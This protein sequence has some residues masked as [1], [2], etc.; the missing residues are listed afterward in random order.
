MKYKKKKLTND[1][2]SPSKH[3]VADRCTNDNGQTKPYIV[4][5]E[6]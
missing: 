6:D 3:E 1:R 2:F 4:C 5:H